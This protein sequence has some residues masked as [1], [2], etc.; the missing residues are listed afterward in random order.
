MA[1]SYED[2]WRE[3]GI[4]LDRNIAGA[5]RK[6]T[7]D[8]QAQISA[9]IVTGELIDTGNYLRSW[10]F[11]IDSDGTRSKV[12]SPVEYGPYLE[13]GYTQKAGVVFPILDAGGNVQGFARTT[14]KQIPARPHVAPAAKSVA[15]RITTYF[16]NLDR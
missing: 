2:K 1:I 10:T 13:Y 3:V 6:V 11:D 7:I 15:R 12:G 5:V 14:G 16:R 8:V 4:R 9:N